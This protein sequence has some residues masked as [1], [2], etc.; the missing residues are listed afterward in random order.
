[1]RHAVKISTRFAFTAF[2]LCALG[3]VFFS[4]FQAVRAD[5]QRGPSVT[6]L[7]ITRAPSTQELMAAG[8]LGGELYPTCPFK[9]A[10]YMARVNLSFGKAIQAWNG[11][12]YDLAAKLFQEHIAAFPDSPWTAE[13]ELHVGCYAYY[14]G[15][16]CDAE[17]AFSRIIGQNLGGSLPGQKAL[18]SKA[19]LRLGV[20]R[21]AQD[22][23]EEAMDIFA[24]LKAQGFDWRHRTYAA[25]WI[26]RL[27][28]YNADRLALLDCGTKAL[29]Y[30][31]EKR[32]K[33]DA[34]RYLANIKPQTLD[35]ITLEV[36]CDLAARSGL[37]MVAVR[38]P[39]GDVTKLPLPAIVFVGKEGK[40]ENGHYWVLDRSEKERIELLDP[41]S[42]Q[43]FNQTPDEFAGEWSGIALICADG[44]EAPGVRLSKTEMQQVFG[45]C[46]GHPRPPDHLGN[47]SPNAGPGGG[48][49][50]PPNG[51]PTWSVNMINLNHNVADTPLWY[52]SPIGPPVNIALNYNS[53]SSITY[54]EP[55][56]S[57]WQFNYASYLVVDPT[58]T[59]TIFMPD[60]RIDV[61]APDGSG[62]YV[63]PFQVFNNLIKKGPHHYEL[64][65]PDGA[66]YTYNIPAG[67]SSMQPFLVGITDPHGQSLTFGYNSAVQLTTIT[68][69]MG[70][71]T[72]L[73]YNAQGL[74]TQAKDPFG[75][76]ASFIYDSNRNL[77]QITDMGGYW[78]KLTYDEDI[79]IT[80]IE[81]SSGTWQFYTEPADGIFNNTNDYPSPGGAMW[82]DYRITVTNPV[83]GTQEYHYDGH[84]IYSWYVSPRD[85]V[86]YVS[87][88]I[89]NFL[90]APQTQYFFEIIGQGDAISSINY[91]GGGQVKFGYDANGNQTSITDADNNTTNLTYNNMGMV[92]SVMDPRGFVTQFTYAANGVDLLETTNGLGSVTRT[93]DS[94]HDVISVQERTGNQWKF[95][96]DGY[97]HP[98]TATDPIG[99]ATTFS[100]DP[101]HQLNKV[102]TGGLVTGTLSYDTMGRVSGRTDAAGSTTTYAYNNINNVTKISYSDGKYVAFTYADCCP[103]LIEQATDRAGRVTQ[104]EHDA[105]KRLTKVIYPTGDSISYS[106]DQNGNLAGIVDT[107]GNS[108]SFSYDLNNRMIKKTY[109]DGT[110]TGFSYD[111]AGL[112]TSRTNARGIVTVYGYDENYNLTTLSYSD[113]TPGATFAYDDYNRPVQRNDAAGTY[114]FSYDKDSRL[115]SI[116]GPWGSDAVTYQYD[117]LG[118][119][120][121]LTVQG[122]P[123]LTYT[124]D[125]LSRLTNI[126]NGAESYTYA[127]SGASPL[128][129]KLTRPNGSKT[130]YQYDAV[131]RLNL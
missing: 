123:S 45:T 78:A 75:R 130:V 110:S 37:E 24:E 66:V 70:R 42:K 92:T 127:Y 76:T 40:G 51:S 31:L 90:S 101:K 103:N 86:P 33:E 50:C 87:S 12:E 53:Q 63:Q 29:Q 26:Q 46:C 121:S 77:I 116:D 18:L 80:G 62:G 8:Q 120:S 16:Y 102:T 35:G 20:L 47:P 19:R 36:L 131:E 9:N 48:F 43:R 59:V 64:H 89:N 56:G 39:V 17:D 84:L 6:P 82:A 15:R 57:K 38:L 21:V 126:Q 96:Y 118:R 1:M 91:P 129:Q 106:Y 22:R 88:S 10:T 111:Q 49:A 79:Y 100:Y 99:T 71:V 72:K 67:T 44:E 105:M 25:H 74:V 128:V 61:F 65:F 93:Y 98:Q 83:G 124:Y 23:F 97:G 107:N 32:G 3:W 109:A 114:L 112:L 27:S 30:V 52:S 7:D 28:R 4:G 122:G 60:G 54:L 68:D 5:V 58:G 2:L 125:A 119:R 13:A 115:L 113:A 104:Y 117:A 85:Y 14:H 69:A 55:F 108:T 95:T 11:H 34:A 81:N 41:Q 94:T 73:T